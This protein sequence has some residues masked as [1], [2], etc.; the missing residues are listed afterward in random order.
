MSLKFSHVVLVCALLLFSD[1]GL[2]QSCAVPAASWVYSYSN[3]G[4]QGTVATASA[5]C[6]AF[7]GLPFLWG[8]NP[9]TMFAQVYPGSQEIPTSR[10]SSALCS[11]TVSWPAWTDSNGNTHASGTAGLG[12]VGLSPVGGG[13]PLFFVAAPAGFPL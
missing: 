8:G 3:D 4:I 2:A 5:G 10:N 6:E 12:E 9:G 1:L 7:N 13:C 11:T